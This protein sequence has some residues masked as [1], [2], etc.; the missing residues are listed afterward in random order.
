M[1]GERL[2]SKQIAAAL[3]VLPAKASQAA[4]PALSKVARL[5]LRFPRETLASLNAAMQALDRP[6]ADDRLTQRLA[7]YLNEHPPR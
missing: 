1:P 2:T 5:L 7:D 3:D 4:N 6:P